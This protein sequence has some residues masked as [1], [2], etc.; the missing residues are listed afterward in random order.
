M[1]LDDASTNFSSF[2]SG[3]WLPLCAAR[4]EPGSEPDRTPG[5]APKHFDAIRRRRPPRIAAAPACPTGTGTAAHPE[6]RS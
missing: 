5:G 2:S 3:S 4:R 6:K 1:T